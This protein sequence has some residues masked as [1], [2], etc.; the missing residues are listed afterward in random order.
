MGNQDRQTDKMG[1]F[2]F[3]FHL[4]NTKSRYNV[5]FVV[6]KPEFVACQQHGHTPAYASAQSDKP[7]YYLFCLFDSLHPNQQFFSYVRTYLPRL[8]QY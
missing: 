7:L 5:N 6:R 1:C 2:G 3:S 4:V 8:N